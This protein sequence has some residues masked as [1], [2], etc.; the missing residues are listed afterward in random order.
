MNTW[1]RVVSLYWIFMAKEEGAAKTVCDKVTTAPIL[2]PPALQGKK[3]G[4]IGSNAE[5]GKK[6]EVRGRCFMF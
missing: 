1:H 3:G 2:R 4:G 6:G 5:P